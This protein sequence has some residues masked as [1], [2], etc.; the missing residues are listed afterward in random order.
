M[1]SPKALIA[2]LIAAVMYLI[3]NTTF[4]WWAA[5]I[6]SIIIFIVAMERLLQGGS[7]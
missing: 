7:R 5:L 6:I 3:V 4:P 1:K 2:S